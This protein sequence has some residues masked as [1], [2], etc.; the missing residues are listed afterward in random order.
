MKPLFYILIILLVTASCKKDKYDSNGNGNIPPE[1]PITYTISKPD[2]VDFK[3]K[4]GTY[5]VYIDSVNNTIDSVSVEGFGFD[6]LLDE[7]NYYEYHLFNTISYPSM[8][9]TQYAVNPFGVY[10]GGN[11]TS[12]SGQRIYLGNELNYFTNCL[13]NPVDSMYIYNQYYYDVVRIEVGNDQTENN[14]KSFYYIN[15]EFGFLRHDMY[16]GG[17]LISKR[18][19][20]DKNIVR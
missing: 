10:K 9:T 8:E 1:T 17:S 13:S 11:G 16:S 6:S 2:L 7:G 5:W 3:F 14:Y 12:N 4:A 15:S 20:V 18:I 19:L